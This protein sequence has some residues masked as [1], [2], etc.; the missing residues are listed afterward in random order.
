MIN[1]FTTLHSELCYNVKSDA[2]KQFIL[3]R[4]FQSATNFYSNLLSRL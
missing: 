4:E 3:H 1:L 2:S